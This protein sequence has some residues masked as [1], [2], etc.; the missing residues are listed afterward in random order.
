[1]SS[2]FSIFYNI[3]YSRI[4]SL[5]VIFLLSLETIDSGCGNPTESDTDKTLHGKTNIVIG[6]IPEQNVFE[7]KK[8]Y[9][10]LF[11]LVGRISRFNLTAY[12]L[13]S[14]GKV[15]DVFQQKRIDGA[16]LGSFSTLA[17]HRALRGKPLVT[18]VYS[19]GASYYRG[20]IIT[21]RDSGVT[22]NVASWRGRSL[23]MVHPN[24]SAGFLFP[25]KVLHDAKVSDISRFLGGHFFLGS[26]DAVV[27]EVWEGRMDIGAVKNTTFQSVISKRPD[28]ENDIKV[29]RASSSFPNITLVMRADL[30]QILLSDLTRVFLELHKSRQG[31]S[32]L[33]SVG[34]SHF[35][36]ASLKGYKNVAEMMKYQIGVTMPRSNAS[37]R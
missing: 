1:M 25:M 37:V 29:L 11:D 33:K 15:Y 9:G 36:K 30:P 10:K 24:T 8:L 7:Q 22:E 6:L 21:R 4:L 17:I 13:P 26:H 5:L 35:I 31:R 12:V 18:Q 27:F 19:N 20:L 14:Y 34:L 3:R 23:A 16:F 28:I 2:T 32:V